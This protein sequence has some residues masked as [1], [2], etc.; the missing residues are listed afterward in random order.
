MGSIEDVRISD[1]ADSPCKLRK[2]SD[3]TIEFDFKPGKVLKQ[4][5]TLEATMYD[6]AIAKSKDR[7]LASFESWSYSRI[8]NHNS[9]L[10]NRKYARDLSKNISFL[11][12][13]SE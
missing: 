13:G 10:V 8:Q 3:V 6:V 9:L 11:S 2:G 12:V 7:V 5:T 4:F 1:C